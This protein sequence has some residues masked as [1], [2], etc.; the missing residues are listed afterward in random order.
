MADTV[1]EVNAGVA[2][3]GKAVPGARLTYREVPA[4]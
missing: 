1:V 3:E 4:R 2:D